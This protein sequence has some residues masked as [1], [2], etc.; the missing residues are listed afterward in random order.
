MIRREMKRNKI[1]D[2]DKLFDEVK[3]L[4][5]HIHICDTSSVLFGLDC[6]EMNAGDKADICGVT[7]FLSHAFKGKMV[8]FI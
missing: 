8:L 7:T 1:D 3:E 6:R 5:A 4:G 2:I